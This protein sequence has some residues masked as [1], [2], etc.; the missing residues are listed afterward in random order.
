MRTRAFRSK[1]RSRCSRCW[2][3]GSYGCRRWGR[4]RWAEGLEVGEVVGEGLLGLQD[5]VD[6]GGGAFAV[7]YCLFGYLLAK[8]PRL[9]GCKFG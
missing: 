1:I 6:G 4:G 7:A 8:V 9:R 5:F 2:D 3:G